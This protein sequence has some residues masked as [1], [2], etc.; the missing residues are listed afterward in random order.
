MTCS[1]I[2]PPSFPGTRRW[3]AG[4]SRCQRITATVTLRGTVGSLREKREAGKT[5]ARV[6]G[7]TEVCSELQVRML[8]G[9]TRDDADLGGDV[10]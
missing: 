1:S 9:S 8:A 5:A 6:Y 10:L 4:R 7:V 2:S 3:T